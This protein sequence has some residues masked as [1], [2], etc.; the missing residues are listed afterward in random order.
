MDKYVRANKLLIFIHTELNLNY[1]FR[2]VSRTITI[3]YAW[4]RK[5]NI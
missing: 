2:T 5:S 4:V 1:K 3:I